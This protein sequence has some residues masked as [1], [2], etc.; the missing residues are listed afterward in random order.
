MSLKSIFLRIKNVHIYKTKCRMAAYC[1]GKNIFIKVR[2]IKNA[3][4]R[5]ILSLLL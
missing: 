4:I 3:R 5:Q 1:G 2:Q